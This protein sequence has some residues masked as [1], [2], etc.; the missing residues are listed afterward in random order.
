VPPIAVGLGI[1]Y[2][3]ATYPWRE[4]LLFC[5]WLIFARPFLLFSIRTTS[6]M[7]EVLGIK[8]RLKAEPHTVMMT[9]FAPFGVS[10]IIEQLF[11]FVNGKIAENCIFSLTKP[12]Q[13]AII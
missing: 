2:K 5:F 6:L 13:I 12:A 10:F 7:L 8:F 4:R 9:L 11:G 3:T 1:S